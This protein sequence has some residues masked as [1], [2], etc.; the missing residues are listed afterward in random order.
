M[1]HNYDFLFCICAHEITFVFW[2]L[3]IASYVYMLS[4]LLSYLVKNIALNFYLADI[5]SKTL[6]HMLVLVRFI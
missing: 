5:D 3:N 2:I 1:R 4:L 6:K